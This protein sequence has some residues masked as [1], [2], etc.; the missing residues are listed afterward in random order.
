M[1]TKGLESSTIAEIVEEADVGVG[2][3]Y[4]HF[5]SKEELAQAVFS[6]VVEEF[7]AA[8]EQVTR[9]QP[10]AAISTCFAIRRLIEQAERDRAWAAFIIQLE[11][12]LQMLDRL[13]RDHARVGVQMG[14]D[15]GMFRVDDVEFAITA[16]HAVTIAIVKATLE[17]QITHKAAHRASA[18]PLR[19]VGVSEEEANRLAALSM[20]A[21]RKEARTTG[22]KD[23][24]PK[25]DKAR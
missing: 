14:V 17:G 1:R 3:F 21:L 12:S 25:E 15:S 2:S 19:M 22:G 18:L 20:T 5:T 23:S 8:L 7:G 13:L 11:P 10:N 9:K 4:N 6:T 24:Q 16:I